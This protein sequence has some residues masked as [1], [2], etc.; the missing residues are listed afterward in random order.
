MASAMY[1]IAVIPDAALA[2][3]VEELKTHVALNYSSVRALRSPAHITLQPPFYLDTE[4]E[5][6]LMAHLATFAKSRHSFEVVLESFSHFDKRVIFIDVLPAA[7]LTALRNDL[8]QFL[9]VHHYPAERDLSF[10]PH[11]TIAFRD[12]SKKNF[13]KAWTEFRHRTFSEKFLADGIALLKHNGKHWEVLAKIPFILSPSG[14][15]G[16]L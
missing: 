7:E 6:P 1:F 8:L 11:I 12:L 10:K 15:N 5:G 9:K 14:P 16:L 3:R 13:D 2:A 4:T